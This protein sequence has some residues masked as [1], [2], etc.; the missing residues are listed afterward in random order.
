VEA[1]ETMLDVKELI[2]YGMD[3]ATEEE[4]TFPS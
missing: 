1:D 3:N 4:F 2:R